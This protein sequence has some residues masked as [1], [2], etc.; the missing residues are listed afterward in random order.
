MK[1]FLIDTN[2]V[3]EFGRSAAPPDPRVITWMERTPSDS[4]FVSVLSLGEI[5][6]G[7]ELLPPGRKRQDLE[8]WLDA[9]LRGWFGGRLLPVTKSIANRWGILDAESQRR[10]K[11]L[12]NI[13]GLLAATAF[14]HKLPRSFQRHRNCPN[15]SIRAR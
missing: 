4:L 11:P 1:G 8:E 2:V 5:R 10:G 13:D 12:S 3:S 14:E 6:R 7:I 9:D 15:P